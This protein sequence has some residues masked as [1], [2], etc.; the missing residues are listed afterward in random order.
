MDASLYNLNMERAVLSS[1][2]FEPTVYEEVSSVL[3]ASAFYLPAHQNVF[4]AMEELALEDMPIDEE[5]IKI[6]LQNKSRFDEAALL[7]ILAANPL[8]NTK[9]YLEELKE[10]SLKRELIKLTTEIKKVTLEENATSDEALDHVQAKLY[11][12]TADTGAKDFRDGADIAKA[13]IELIHENKARGN[14]LVVGLDTGFHG[15]NKKTSGFGK[16]DLIIIAARPAMGKTAFVLNLAANVL[17]HNLGVAF[18]SLE[19][20]AEQLMLRMLAARCSIS[21]Q[22]LK[23]GDLDDQQWTSLSEGAQFFSDSKLFVDDDSSLTIQKLRS[24]LRELKAKHPEVSLCVIDYLQLM[25]GSGKER[26]QEVSD[27]SRGIKI[28]ARELE[29]PIIALSQLNR[30]VESR[31]D[32]RPMLADIR[33]SGAIEQ[34][35]DIIMFVYRE[36]VYAE[37]ELRDKIKDAEQNGNADKANEYKAKLDLMRQKP[38]EKAE[39][40]IGKHRNGPTG[41]VNMVFQKG[42]TRFEDDT[43]EFHEPQVSFY[44]DTAITVSVQQAPASAPPPSGDGGGTPNID[45]PII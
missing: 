37:R 29:M 45:V 3:K 8:S 36:D 40:I 4:A 1:I 6:R 14:T 44:K 16:G 20:P 23:T 33:E 41:T 31:P 28:L 11:E 38:E 19:M 2:L 12:I 21:M 17:K 34:D 26:Q 42:F 25:S 10:L 22:R 9:A 7:D 32:K 18:F 27:I 24:K 43:E 5:F 15:L 30:A 39:L 13:T 35:A